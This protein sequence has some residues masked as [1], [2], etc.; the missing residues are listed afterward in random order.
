MI[1][2]ID[3][4]SR[5]CLGEKPEYSRI[6]RCFGLLLLVL[7]AI[8]SSGC[9]PGKSVDHETEITPPETW[10]S[11]GAGNKQP[12]LPFAIDDELQS[13][14]SD[15]V[16]N[17]HSL[18]AMAMRV[19]RAQ[20]FFSS[21]TG[22]RFPQ[23]SVAFTHDRGEVRSGEAG[24]SRIESRKYEPVGTLS[25]ELD[26]WGK[27]R[28]R[29]LASGKEYEATVMDWQAA[30]FSLCV[31]IAKGWYEGIAAG[32]LMRQAEEV[33]ESY[34]KTLEAVEERYL[35]GLAE[36][37]DLHMAR[38]AYSQALSQQISRKS[39]REQIILGL[40]ALAGYYPDGNLTLPA[41]LPDPSV[42]VL[43]GLPADMVLSRPDIQASRLRIEA[44][45]REWSAAIKELLPTI[46]LSAAAGTDSRSYGGI[47]DPEFGFW[48][49]VG[50]LT[51]PVFK[52]GQL[53]SDAKESEYALYQLQQEHCDLILNSFREVE[54]ALRTDKALRNQYQ[55]AQKTVRYAEDSWNAAV[56]Q[57][58]LGTVDLLTVLINQRQY[59][60]SRM[61]LIELQGALFANSMDLIAALGNDHYFP[62]IAEIDVP[63]G[64]L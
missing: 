48:Q 18:G 14:I 31:R 42:Q 60:Q 40:Q 54:A 49:L 52:G 36:A 30:R 4:H 3:L 23:A 11:A 10:S 37:L 61:E 25:W 15:A 45:D 47:L 13:F 35:S 62:A 8:S 39:D 43:S 51:Q 22:A 21:T 59:L 17:S 2:R 1:L 16:E 53:R 19:G 7:A 26:L 27:I 6:V 32:L 29:S 46:T 38:T 20:A 9:I 63:Q 24:G 12:P 33:T 5:L 34:K 58:R 56:E 50:G 41:H 64:E 57:Y 55:Q 44:A 28:D